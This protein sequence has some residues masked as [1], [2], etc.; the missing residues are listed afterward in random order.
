MTL[1]YMRTFKSRNFG[2]SENVK[3]GVR[4]I[5]GSRKN[6]NSNNEAGDEYVC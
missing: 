1:S 5:R 3:L 6:V 4:L 2:N